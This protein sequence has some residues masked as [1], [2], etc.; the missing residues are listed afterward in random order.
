MTAGMSAT[1]VL[2]L[3]IQILSCMY[4]TSN[5][6]YAIIGAATK[7]A[8]PIYGTAVAAAIAAAPATTT[9]A[10]TAAPTAAPSPFAVVA[11]GRAPFKGD[12]GARPIFGK[13][14]NWYMLPCTKPSYSSSSIINID[15]L[16]MEYIRP[17]MIIPIIMVVPFIK[18][19]I[20]IGTIIMIT[21]LLS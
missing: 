2:I 14:G 17:I 15:E 4:H 5:I 7:A 10:T 21:W 6:S 1:I 3:V 11:Q 8:K 9:T 16:V 13:Y 18:S 12:M 20:M 19:I